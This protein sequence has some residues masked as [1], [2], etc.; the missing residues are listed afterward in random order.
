MTTTVATVVT[1]VKDRLLIGTST[2]E[3]DDTMLKRWVIS[4]AKWAIGQLQP[5]KET[6]VS[7]TSGPSASHTADI[8]YFVANGHEMLLDS[9]WSKQGSTIKLHSHAA[10][11]SDTLTIWSFTDP[12]I[13][14]DVTTF[15]TTCI[16]GT[17]WLE[18]LITVMACMQAEQRRAFLAAS[19][20]AGGHASSQRVLQDERNQLLAP[21]KQVRDEWLGMMGQRLAARAQFGDTALRTSPYSKFKNRSSKRNPLTGVG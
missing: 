13:A 1:D 20:D 11:P 10:K 12:D 17:D 15:D 19:A 7:V 21:Y 2:G 18:E 6:T 14:S 8:V 5:P 4:S 9:E 3:P 16:F